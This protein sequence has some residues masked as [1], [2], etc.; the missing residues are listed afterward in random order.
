M[1]DTRALGQRCGCHRG[2][3]DTKAIVLRVV[4]TEPQTYALS[5]TAPLSAFQAL[6]V[7]LALCARRTPLRP[8]PH[9]TIAPR[10]STPFSVSPAE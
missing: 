3:L 5:Y 1:Q 8:P 6:C 4:R 2:S 10:C 7:T 9:R